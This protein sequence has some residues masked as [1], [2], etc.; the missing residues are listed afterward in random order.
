MY[1]EMGYSRQ[2]IV[3]R[4]GTTIAANGPGAE[5]PTNSERKLKMLTKVICWLDATLHD[6]KAIASLEY[7]IIAAAILGAVGAAMTILKGDISNLFNAV[8][9]A[10]VNATG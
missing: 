3:T 4:R 6:R 9:N 8:I 2:Q 7:G 10:V 5:P 1:S